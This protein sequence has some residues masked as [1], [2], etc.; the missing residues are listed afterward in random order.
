LLCLTVFAKE[1]LMLLLIVQGDTLIGVS[2]DNSEKE[3][4]L[5]L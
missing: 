5:P 2:M 4:C 1:T 3:G